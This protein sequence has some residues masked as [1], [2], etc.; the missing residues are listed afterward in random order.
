MIGAK[1]ITVA[2]KKVLRELVEF[3]CLGCK[4][5]EDLVGTLH[6]HRIIRGNAGGTYAPNNV[7]MICRGCHGLRHEMEPGTK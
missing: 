7:Q 2:Q 6:A 3:T 4:K 5:H 1:T